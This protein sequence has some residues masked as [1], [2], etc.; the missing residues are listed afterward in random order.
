M[1]TVTRLDDHRPHVAIITQANAVH[2]ISVAFFEAVARGELTVDDLDGRDEILRI[3]IAEWLE[4]IG[5]DGAWKL[6]EMD[7]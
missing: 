1:G 7:D 3:V 2:V 4:H 5:V 6:R